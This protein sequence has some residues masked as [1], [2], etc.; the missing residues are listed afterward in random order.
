MLMFL[1]VWPFIVIHTIAAWA[2]CH[3]SVNIFVSIFMF[4]DCLLKLFCVCV[5]VC[6]CVFVFVDASLDTCAGDV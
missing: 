1:A 5:C 4:G 6:V 3:G 2:F